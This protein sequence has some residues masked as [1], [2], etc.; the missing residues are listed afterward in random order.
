MKKLLLSIFSALLIAGCS[1]T[2]E[3]EEPNDSFSQKDI[4]NY[5]CTKNGV[6]V[7]QKLFIGTPK[8]VSL[9]DGKAIF[10]IVLLNGNR[11]QINL[12]DYDKCQY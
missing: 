10:E 9:D 3:K 5:T 1:N 12:L 4:K 6:V 7:F 11:E 2:Y 8:K